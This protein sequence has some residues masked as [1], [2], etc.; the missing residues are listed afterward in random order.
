MRH[1]NY[2]MRFEEIA[3]L[4]LI[5]R[6]LKIKCI[7]A[8]MSRHFQ[9]YIALLLRDK[10]QESMFECKN[11]VSSWMLRKIRTKIM[12]I[13][14]WK[15]RQKI[16]FQ[17]RDFSHKFKSMTKFSKII[18]IVI[19]S[20]SW[21]EMNKMAQTICNIWNNC[22]KMIFYNRIDNHIE[23]RTAKWYSPSRDIG[24]P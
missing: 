20:L 11:K 15:I 9:K 5:F 24:K 8:N 23:Y 19:S 3:D 18:E 22:L 13:C 10:T 17:H 7:P 1:E 4:V 16:R 21:L 6:Y 14:V 12:W 2:A